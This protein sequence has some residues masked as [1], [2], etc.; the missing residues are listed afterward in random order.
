MCEDLDN[1][2]DVLCLRDILVKANS[3]EL[4]QDAVLKMTQSKLA[5][6]NM[7]QKVNSFHDA[8]RDKL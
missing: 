3:G 4:H 1:D 5:E 6:T 7:I 8:K 2:P